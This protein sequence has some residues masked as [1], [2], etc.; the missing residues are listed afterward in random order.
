MAHHPLLMWLLFFYFSSAHLPMSIP[1]SDVEQNATQQ[2]GP[3][4]GLG[5]T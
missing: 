1:D 5:G 2:K 4:L 3:E